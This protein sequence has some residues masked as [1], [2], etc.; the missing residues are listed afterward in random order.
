VLS[1][2]FDST[3]RGVFWRLG[4][5]AFCKHC[6]FSPIQF[7]NLLWPMQFAYFLPY[8]FLALCHSRVTLAGRSAWEADFPLAYSA[9]RK[10]GSVGKAP[11]SLLI[12]VDQVVRE[13]FF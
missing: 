8:T 1:V 9:R 4:H 2:A 3:Q 6:L 12:G 7:Q 5:M 13:S 11:P 10:G